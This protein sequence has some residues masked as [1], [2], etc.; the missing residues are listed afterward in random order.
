MLFDCFFEAAKLAAAQI[1]HR[2]VC[3][4]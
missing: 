2:S 3:I 4:S 1:R